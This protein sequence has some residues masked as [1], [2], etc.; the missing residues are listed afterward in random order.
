[1]LLDTCALLWLVTGG[2]RMSKDI[3][4]QIDSA[5]VVFIS[6]IS[7]FEIT[8]KYQ[9]GKLVL[10]VSPKEWFE[11]VTEYHDLSVIPLDLETCIKSADLPKIHKDPCDRFIIAAALINRLPVVTAD[12]RF[13]Q[14]GVKVIF[15]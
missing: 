7:G 9:S 13:V 12:T 3:M 11:T 1:M 6:A 2:G 14:Y 15:S 4:N 10:P 8:L 5:P